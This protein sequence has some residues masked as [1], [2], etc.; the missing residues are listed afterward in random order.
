MKVLH[1]MSLNSPALQVW[2]V[3]N[4]DGLIQTAHCNCVAGLSES[5]GHVGAILF[6]LEALYRKHQQ[7]NQV[8]NL[9]LF[10]LL[11]LNKFIDLQ[12]SVTDIKATWKIPPV[13]H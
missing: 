5:C 2:I 3:V 7:N 10:W 8:Y 11:I 12:L 4:L 6:A 9:M 13:K 1:T